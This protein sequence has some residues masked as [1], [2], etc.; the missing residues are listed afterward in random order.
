[1]LDDNIIPSP[2]IGMYSDNFPFKLPRKLFVEQDLFIFSDS[3]MSPETF[4]SEA[5]LNV[6]IFFNSN[7]W[8]IIF[9]HGKKVDRIK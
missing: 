7:L 1:M 4:R 8:Y 9:F 3:R 6:N 5:T 2:K